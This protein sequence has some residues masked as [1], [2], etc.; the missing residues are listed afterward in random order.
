MLILAILFVV[1]EYVAHALALLK[2]PSLLGWAPVF[3]I[4]FL[5]DASASRSPSRYPSPSQ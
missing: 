5:I 4:G 3:A 1:M 2:L